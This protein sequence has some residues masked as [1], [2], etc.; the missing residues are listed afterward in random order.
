MRSQRSLADELKAQTMRR[1]LPLPLP[2]LRRR[3]WAV[4]RRR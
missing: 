4:R 3:D 1:P 2:P